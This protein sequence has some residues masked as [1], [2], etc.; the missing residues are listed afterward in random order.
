VRK[1]GRLSVNLEKCTGCRICEIVCSSTRE[2]LYAP[3]VSRVRLVQ[4]EEKG[5]DCP[6]ACKLCEKPPCVAACPTKAL[7]Q[8]PL[9]HSVIVKKALCIGC[10]LCVEYCPIGAISI[11]PERK[12][13]A[14]CDLCLGE[15]LC[16]KVCPTH[17]IEFHNRG[18][19]S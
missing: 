8:H 7:T 15:P 13:A 18:G 5:F 2:G 10:G 3:K 16:Q 9:R 4:N 17:A 14:V 11:H 12:M 1:T 19:G 6:I